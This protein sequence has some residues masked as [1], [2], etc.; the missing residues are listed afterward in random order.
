MKKMIVPFMKPIGYPRMK[1]S[2]VEVFGE[3]LQ[4]GSVPSFMSSLKMSQKRR[5]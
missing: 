3:H 2:S 4:E 5:K 1:D